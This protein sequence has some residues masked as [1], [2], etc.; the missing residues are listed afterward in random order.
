MW[1]SVETS[2][3]AFISRQQQHRWLNLQRPKQKGR[4]FSVR[5]LTGDKVFCVTDII[6]I[7]W[8][9]VKKRRIWVSAYE[10]KNKGRK[11]DRG[12]ERA[13]AMTTMSR[14][15]GTVGDMLS[16]WERYS[17]STGDRAELPERC[18]QLYLCLHA[19]SQE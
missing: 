17:T 14:Q 5:W 18:N 6:K 15:L 11:A 10:G 9:E 3:W 19:S 8:N 7:F 1:T 4:K 12:G 13:V 2:R 16:C